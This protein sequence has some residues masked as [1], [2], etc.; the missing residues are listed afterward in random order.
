MCRSN[1]EKTELQIKALNLLG[2]LLMA[3]ALWAA[4]VKAGAI[5]AATAML[6]RKDV[7][8]ASA[9]KAV[10]MLYVLL[11]CGFVGSL[12]DEPAGLEQLAAAASGR[13]GAVPAD[14]ARKALLEITKKAAK[15]ADQM[16]ESGELGGDKVEE[17]A[18][19]TTVEVA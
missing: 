1:S 18:G 17:E 4:V 14:T 7:T 10:G 15:K 6:K 9:T 11:V 12:R 3:Q 8:E 19:E 13:Y 5:G 16:R 2:G